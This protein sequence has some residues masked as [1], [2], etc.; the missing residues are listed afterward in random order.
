MAQMAQMA[1]MAHESAS[2]RA[3]ESA[4]H[5]FGEIGVSGLNDID[6]RTVDEAGGSIG[7]EFDFHHTAVLK[8]DHSPV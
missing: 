6:W 7:E 5:H 3:G 1:Q 8:G 2:Q 4:S